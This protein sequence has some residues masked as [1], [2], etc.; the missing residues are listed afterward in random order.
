MSCL[1]EAKRKVVEIT[2]LSVFV[3]LS[4]SNFGA[5]LPIFT[6][7]GMSIIPFR[8]IYKNDKEFIS[9]GP[10]E[11]CIYL[12]FTSVYLAVVKTQNTYGEEFYPNLVLMGSNK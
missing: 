9:D 1:K 10:S 5:V 11:G 3:C 12:S 2:I 4:I 6:R 7:L 8:N